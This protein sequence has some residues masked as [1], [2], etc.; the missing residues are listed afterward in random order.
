MFTLGGAITGPGSIIKVGAGNLMLNGSNGFAGLSVNT[1]TVTLGT[2]TAVGVGGIALANGTTLV[3]G[4]SGLVLANSIETAGTDTVDTAG[5]FTMNGAISGSGTISKIGSGNL[6]LNGSNSFAGLG[7]TAGTVTVGSSKAAGTGTVALAGGTT[8]AAGA[9]GLT[10]ANAITTAGVGTVNTKGFD[11]TLSGPITGPGSIVETGGGSLNVG[12]VDSFAGPTTVASGQLR[13]TGSLT[14]SLVAV[15]GGASLR[16]TGSVAGLVASSGST[17]APGLGTTL[18][19][20]SVT[21]NTTFQPGSTFAV[22]VGA[23]TADRLTVTGIATLTGTLAINQ[24]VG[25]LVPATSY[26]LL[27]AAGGRTGIFGTVIYGNATFNAA[28]APTVSYTANTVLLSLQARSLMALAGGSILTPNERNVGV[29]YDAGVAGGFSP[30]GFAA[31]FA[32]GLNLPDAL[33]QLSGEVLSAERRVA[34]DD[35]RHVREAALDRL[36]AGL[37]AISGKTIPRR[38][39]KMAAAAIP[40]GRAASA[41]GD[42]AAL[43][44]TAARSAPAPAA[45]SSAST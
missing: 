21:G 40:C 36:G 10:L 20:L 14:N 5:V 41:R 43:T 18:G 35:T 34:M 3:A 30:A 1:G 16:G 42:R 38:R 2:S 24:L 23:T 27:S 7:V 11:L 32:P 17:V 4:V 25:P 45:R 29:A 8:L 22:N 13:V 15:A 9:T 12:G 26:T 19:T 6:A 37:A 31:L 39:P 44:A 28:Y 33:N